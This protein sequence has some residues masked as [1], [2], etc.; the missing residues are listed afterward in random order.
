MSKLLE[1]S[2]RQVNI[3]LINEI[4]LISERMNINIWD[5]IKAAKTKILVS[6]LL[7][8]GLEQVVTVYLLTQC[9]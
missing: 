9:I 1:N 8:L 4:K 2:F 3:G 6:Q 7:V 5:V